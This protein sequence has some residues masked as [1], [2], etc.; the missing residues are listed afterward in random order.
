MVKTSY[1]GTP[2]ELRQLAQ[3]SFQQRDRYILGVVQSQRRELSRAKKRELSRAAKVASPQ[4]GRGSLFKYFSPFWRSLTSA[5]KAVWT[6]AAAVSGLN[7]WQLF[8]SDSAARIKNYLQFG[9]DPNLLW[10]VRTGYIKIESPANN[11]LLK[12]EHPLSYWVQSHVRGMSWKKTLQNLTEYFS[13]PLSLKIRYKSNLIPSGSIQRLRY[14]AIVKSSY[15]GVDRETE[16]ICNLNPSTDWA[17]VSASLS[18][19][20]GYIISY[21]LYIEVYGYVGELFIDNLRCEHGGFNWVRDPKSNEMDK[22][23]IKQFAIIKP[24][25]EI[26]NQPVGASF[27]SVFPPAL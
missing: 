4:K 6:Q 26:V 11:I 8:I 27:Q 15:Q 2:D 9:S 14:F 25:W 13:L 21:I 20:I 23:F 16:V 7:G 3:K 18:S 5:Q 12:Q 19:V 17:E 10:Q 24:F 1:V 22:I